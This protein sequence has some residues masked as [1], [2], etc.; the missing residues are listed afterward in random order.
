[1]GKINI[2]NSGNLVY[3]HMHLKVAR[4]TKLFRLRNKV[5]HMKLCAHPQHT[6]W[7]KRIIIIIRAVRVIIITRVVR[8]IKVIKIISVLIIMVI[9]A[10]G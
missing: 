6:F 4:V 5:Q 1:M 10:F 8:V 7:V 2:I 9:R 3:Q